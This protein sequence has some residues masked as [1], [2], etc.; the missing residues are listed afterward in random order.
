MY[1]DLVAWLATSSRG[2]ASSRGS[3]LDTCMMFALGVEPK[4]DL[5]KQR[6]QTSHV[7]LGEMH[8]TQIQLLLLIVEDIDRIK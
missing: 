2:S 5:Y 6:Y 4:V 8:C 7:S 1:E 3:G